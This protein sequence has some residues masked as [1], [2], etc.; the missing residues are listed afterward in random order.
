MELGDRLQS[1]ETSLKEKLEALYHRLDKLSGGVLSIVADSI[2]RFTDARGSEAAAAMAYYTL[3]SLFP[4]L[5]AL[6]AV[7]G[8]FLQQPRVFNEVVSLLGRA[9]P[10]S[11]SL[12]SD[13]LKQIMQVRG[14]IGIVGLA[15]AVWSGTGVFSVLSNNIN[16]AWK[17]T[18]QRNFLQSRLV[19]LGMAAGLAILLVLSVVGSTVVDVLSQIQVPLL[20]R[21]EVY[22]SPIWMA[23]STVIP[24]V[25]TFL[26]FLALYWWVPTAKVKFSAAFW[27]ALVVTVV[28]EAASS[29]FAFYVSS[30]LAR[31][32]IVYGSL[33]SV[34]ALMFWIYLSSWIV[35]FG[36]HLSAAIAQREQ[37][38]T[39]EV[40]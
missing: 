38:D 5:L 8:F 15:G 26:L 19:A 3:F 21:L 14:A 29:L 28:W 20:Q 6:V 37:A 39:G 9:F 12:I 1:D 17:D 10:I 18:E 34:A 25:F 16:E 22:S 32:K 35:I 2:G 13:N 31:Y 24:W 36:A 40:D 23:A 33:G 27:A 30:G 4:L 11:H 7:G